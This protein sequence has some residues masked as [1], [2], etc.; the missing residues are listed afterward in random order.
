M[1]KPTLWIITELF[2]PNEDATAYI[3]TEY[4][5]I[6]SRKYEVKVIC[7]TSDSPEILEGYDVRIERTGITKLNK[8]KT[9]SRILKFMYVG[10]SLAFRAFKRCRRS[11]RVLVVT[12]PVTMP[13]F[14]GIVNKLRNFDYTLLV[15]DIF[16]ENVVAAG[17][18]R[19]SSF[20][21]K[22][23]KKIFD[24]GYR[25]ADHL[26][27]LGR[28]MK[29]VVQ[30]KIGKDGGKIDIIENWAEDYI[31]PNIPD[32][33]K[34]PIV[35]Q[36]AGNIGRVQGLMEFIKSVEKADNPDIVF[37]IWGKGAFQAKIEEYIK[38]RSLNNVIIK[39]PYR[40]EDQN[41][42]L[43]SCDIALI[44][45]SDNMYGLGVPSKSYNIMAA[46]KPILFIGDRRSEIGRVVEDN[47]LG[48]VYGANNDELVMFLKSLKR[49]AYE[50][51][52]KVYGHNSA[53]LARLHYTKGEIEKKILD[54]I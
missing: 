20:P 44:S 6:L 31:H 45:L 51:S 43:S 35:I 29:E 18:L 36:Y 49:D 14:I 28:D 12:N 19:T 46:G 34:G 8:D 38:E 5:K 11:D 25:S 2:Y 16:P 26:I 32:E 48:F 7:A 3:L 9:I 50:E 54:T 42:V 27:V 21:Y 13:L 23:I 47:S 53:A 22:I 37:E 24:K 40:R 10:M 39:G 52:I 17:M 41:S 4:A 30:S 15:H 33:A 1:T